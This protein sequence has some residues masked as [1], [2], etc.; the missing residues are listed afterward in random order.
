MTCD[1]KTF[2]SQ[3]KT[4]LNYK[5]P[6]TDLFAGLFVTFM[7]GSE[8]D[9]IRQIHE[10]RKLDVNGVIL[11][12]YAHLGDKYIQALS[13]RAFSADAKSNVKKNVSSVSQE[14]VKPVRYR[15]TIEDLLQS[16]EYTE[17]KQ[18][19]NAKFII[20]RYDPG[21]MIAPAPALSTQKKKY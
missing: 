6:E 16:Q 8:E 2:T 1:H 10:S 20:K 21:K 14:N 17:I 13:K 9:L 15:S 3:V 5:E 12:D 19:Q 4:V 18:E 7:G 11:F